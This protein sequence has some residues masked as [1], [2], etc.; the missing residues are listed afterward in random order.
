M[1]FKKE[2]AKFQDKVVLL[3]WLLQGRNAVLFGG[4]VKDKFAL[5]AKWKISKNP[6]LKILVLLSPILT[7]QRILQKLCLS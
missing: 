2:L 4:L 7:L 5:D 1:D 6:P 3:Q